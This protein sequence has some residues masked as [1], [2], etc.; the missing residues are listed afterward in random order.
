MSLT[1]IRRGIIIPP[2]VLCARKRSIMSAML[3]SEIVETKTYPHARIGRRSAQRMQYRRAQGGTHVPGDENDNTRGENRKSH[4]VRLEGRPS[5][6]RGRKQTTER[7]RTTGN[8]AST[9][10]RPWMSSRELTLNKKIPFTYDQSHRLLLVAHLKS[11]HP[12][13]PDF[14]G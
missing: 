11:C 13:I 10:N 14:R 7:L 8:V 12:Q 6:A 5:Y 9:M 1:S 4:S 3:E 2:L